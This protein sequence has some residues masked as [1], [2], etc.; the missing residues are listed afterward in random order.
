MDHGPANF[1]INEQREETE[2]RGEMVS[3]VIQMDATVAGD[4]GSAVR[5][6]LVA[7]MAARLPIAYSTAGLGA[8]PHSPPVGYRRQNCVI[9]PNFVIIGSNSCGTV[10]K[11]A[12]VRYLVGL[13]LKFKFCNRVKGP[14]Q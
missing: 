9:T 10:F 7:C 2:L 8:Q 1:T 5:T 14:I 12:A 4:D 6:A 11:M 3:R 13:F